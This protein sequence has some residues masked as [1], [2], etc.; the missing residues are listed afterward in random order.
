MTDLFGDSL[1]GPARL[2][3]R[4][5]AVCADPLRQ[6]L[7]QPCH[8]DVLLDLMSDLRVCVESTGNPRNSD[9]DRKTG[10]E[11]HKRWCAILG[12]K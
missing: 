9:L 1:P 8:A 10:S 4:P 7:D 2:D 11:L 12:L 5:P 6:D 3:C